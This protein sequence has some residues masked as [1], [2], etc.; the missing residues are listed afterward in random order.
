MLKSTQYFTFRRLRFLKALSHGARQAD[1]DFTPT[2][3][4]AYS[5]PPHRAL[6]TIYVL[7]R[8]DARFAHYLMAA[9]PHATTF[10]FSL[11]QYH[12]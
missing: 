4:M 2:T 1:V 11:L 12:Y 3:A 8:E 10:N 6:Y 5:S 9:T 7:F